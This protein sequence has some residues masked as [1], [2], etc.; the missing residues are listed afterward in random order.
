ML[1]SFSVENWMSFRDKVVFSMEATTAESRYESTI[2]DIKQQNIK[3]LPAAVIYG[4]NASGKTNLFKA[5]VFMKTFII[6]RRPNINSQIPVFPFRLSK[7][8][9]LKP[10]WFEIEV[11]VDRDLY[12]FSFLVS[13]TAVINEQL[14]VYRN[15]SDELLLYERDEKGQISGS[16]AED[17]KIKTIAEITSSNELFLTNFAFANIELFKPFFDWFNHSL[18]LVSPNSTYI[19]TEKLFQKDEELYKKM[20]QRLEALDTNISQLDAKDVDLNNFSSSMIQSILKYPEDIVRFQNN[21]ERYIAFKD[22]SGL[23]V[24]KLVSLHFDE[25]GDSVEFETS[26][27]SDGSKRVIDLIPAFLDLERNKSL[28]VYFIDEIERSLHHRLTRNLI[29]GFLKTC[30]SASRAQLLFTTHDLLILDSSLFRNDEI[31]LVDR[32]EDAVSRL[33]SLSDFSLSG[34]DQN[35]LKSYLQ[36]RFGGVPSIIEEWSRG[37]D[38]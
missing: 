10:S 38:T 21:S 2:P 7:Q 6:N 26:E 25:D 1:V 20:S 30:S 33:T 32:G 17:Q 18:E 19:P 4:G 14:R 5:L 8:N 37:H 28:K 31:F 23:T 11:I 29:E 3:I 15:G 34:L 16:C 9:I 27:E 36:G 13:T 35:I 24:K 22:E 12:Q